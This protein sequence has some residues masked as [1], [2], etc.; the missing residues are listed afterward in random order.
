MAHRD[1]HPEPVPGCFGCRVQD[2][3]VMTLKIKH[4]PDPLQRIPVI[5]E[6]GKYAGTPGGHHLIHWD[7]RQDATVRPRP[8]AV[9]TR[10][11]EG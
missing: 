5:R 4:G 10:V 11:Q 1:R 7:G 9:T 6:I 2:Q 8:V 3:G